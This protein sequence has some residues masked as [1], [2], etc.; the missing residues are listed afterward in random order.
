[1]RALNRYLG[2]IDLNRK[3]GRVNRPHSPL[4]G[5]RRKPRQVVSE[6]RL[7]PPLEP[8]DLNP[9]CGVPGADAEALVAGKQRLE[10]LR[11]LRRTQASAGDSD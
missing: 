4:T 8:L 1:M 9:L 5:W 7:L 2:R 10:L 3:G 6:R 11:L